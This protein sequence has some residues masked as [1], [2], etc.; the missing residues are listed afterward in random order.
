MKQIII[1]LTCIFTILFFLLPVNATYGKI[2]LSGGPREAVIS[3]DRTYYNYN[4]DYDD[5]NKGHNGDDPFVDS[6]IIANC[7]TSPPNA[8]PGSHPFI[9]PF[10]GRDG[11]KVFPMILSSSI[12]SSDGG[13][14]VF[15]TE[16]FD[17]GNLSS[18]GWYDNTNLNIDNTEY[19]SGSGSVK[20]HFARGAGSPD[21]GGAIR[22][23]FTGTEEL[24]VSYY[25]KYSSGY[26]GSGNSSHPHEFFILSDMDGDWSAPNYTYLQV[27]IEQNA[28]RPR[29]IFRDDKSINTSYGTPET[30]LVG[31]TENRAVHGCNGEQDNIPTDCYQ[32]GGRWYNSKHFLHDSAL[33]ST[34][35]WHKVAVYVKLNSVTGTT[36]NADGIMQY[37]LDNTLVFDYNN[38]VIRTSARPA[39]KFSQFGIA[40]FI[41]NGSPVDQTFWVDDLVIADAPDSS[42][43][44]TNTRKVNSGS[45]DGDFGLGRIYPNPSN[46][47]ITISGNAQW[48]GK[49]GVEI[50]TLEGRK[51]FATP[52]A[53]TFPYQLDISAFRAGIYIIKVSNENEYYT[54]QVVVKK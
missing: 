53:V 54:R 29:I 3:P 20:F 21:S 42:T 30:D 51:L 48:S 32:S 8:D 16:G 38:L 46:T 36:T 7:N 40:P 14:Q 22:H 26:Q 11:D 6:D 49:A 10:A 13:Q 4:L 24:Y 18:R 5:F 35:Q 34:N 47:N 2:D 9:S 15:L 28:L 43:T 37:W 17:D 12:D 25:V 33:I 1:H 27:K 31:Q 44:H 23:K 39:I 45:G 19:H 50:Y 41:G 52:R